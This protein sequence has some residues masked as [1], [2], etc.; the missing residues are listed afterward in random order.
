MIS[1]EQESERL[2]NVL[3][4]LVDQWRSELADIEAQI[5]KL[6]EVLASSEAKSDRSENATFQIAKDERDIKMA[7]MSILQEK[8]SA[9]DTYAGTY[10]PGST[11]KENSTVEVSLQTVNGQP[12][13]VSMDI[14]E[15]YK[16]VQHALSYPENG[17]LSMKSKLGEAILDHMV[18][19]V[20]EVSSPM[21]LIT[22][23]IER[24][25]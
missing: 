13:H 3:V 12:Y 7:N 22:Y 5:V 24:L 17:L 8:I 11:V 9:F 2:N 25:F 18:N 15:I 6:N 20:V 10:T 19:D 1:L 21:G 14:T 16:V 23:K 4:T